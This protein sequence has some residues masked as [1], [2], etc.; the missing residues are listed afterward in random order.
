[1]PAQDFETRLLAAHNQVR[2]AAGVPPLAWSPVLAADAASHGPYLASIERLEHSPRTKRGN[3][4]ENL[5]MGTAG[6]FAPEI[7]V[8]GWAGEKQHFRPGR[9]PDVSTTG[10]WED[11]GHYTQ[12][13]WPGTTQVGCAMARGKG[14]DF[15]IC[16][17][18]PAGNIIG[19]RVP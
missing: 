7:M 17:Y 6:A 19:A 10:R 18:A 8:D 2:R 3:Q 1:V 16:R 9:F 12:M 5:W 15:L 13:I 4:G 11:V 14:W